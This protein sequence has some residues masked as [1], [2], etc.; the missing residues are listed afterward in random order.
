MLSTATNIIGC[1][2]ISIVTNVL[3]TIAQNPRNPSKAFTISTLLCI[4]FTISGHFILIYTQPGLSQSPLFHNIIEYFVSVFAL[5]VCVIRTIKDW[6]VRSFALLPLLLLPL[7]FQAITYDKSEIAILL[8][9]V[10]MV[11]TV[12][13]SWAALRTWERRFFSSL[14]VVASGSLVL[15]LHGSYAVSHAFVSVAGVVLGLVERRKSEI[16]QE[17]PLVA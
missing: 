14:A 10:C 5:S 4:L 2:C 9:D 16:L 15:M 13:L 7:V 1:I 8:Y 3:L 6:R 11:G 12:A 17:E